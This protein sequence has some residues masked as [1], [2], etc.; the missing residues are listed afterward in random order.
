[1][2]G[3]IRHASE[4]HSRGAAG[5]LPALVGY[6]FRACI[7][8]GRLAVLALPALVILSTGLLSRTVTDIPAAESFARITDG[9]VFGLALP[10]GSL[11]IGDAVVGAE[12]RAGTFA[13][14]WLTPARWWELA[15]A[16]WFGGW[17]VTAAVLVPAG[18][19]AAPVAG[20]PSQAPPLA[21]A[22]VAGTSAH[23][24]LFV[25]VGTVARRAAV[26]SLVIVLL[27]ERL[28]GAALSGIAQLS[29]TWEARAVYMGLADVPADLTRSGI[30]D[31][32]DAV[33]RLG[34]LALAFLV[35]TAYGLRRLELSGARD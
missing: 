21:L 33:V 24:A 11:V 16:R 31:S 26:W 15:V 13:F 6:V 19:V 25:L 4:R 12:V 18:A 14:T 28:L 7:P 35:A 29:P 5:R 30:P 2:T 17:I 22:T 10:L 34:L 23:V 8:R 32:W 3:P 20:E 27:V 9:L 1:M